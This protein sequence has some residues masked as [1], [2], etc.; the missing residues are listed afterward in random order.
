MEFI[1]G[2]IAVVAGAAM[3]IKTETLIQWFGRLPWAEDKL[4]PGGTRTFHKLLG[5]IIIFVGLTLMFGL[6]E[7]L[8]GFLLSPLLRF[9]Q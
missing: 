2:V 7:G 6:F 9:Q 8:L 5:L 1:I 4:G 3:V